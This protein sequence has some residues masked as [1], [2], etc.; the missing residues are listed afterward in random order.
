MEAASSTERIAEARRSTARTLRNA[1]SAGTLHVIMEI[2]VA[3]LLPQCTRYGRDPWPP[4]S[5]PSLSE[6]VKFRINANR[7]AMHRSCYSLMLGSRFS[8]FFHKFSPRSFEVTRTVPRYH[9]EDGRGQQYGIWASMFVIR[10]NL[11]DGFSQCSLLYRTMTILTVKLAPIPPSAGTAA[12]PV[13]M[14]PNF[15]PHFLFEDSKLFRAVS[16]LS[17]SSSPPSSKARAHMLATA[18]G[19]ATIMLSTEPLPT[20]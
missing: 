3:G 16:R 6:T 8:F 15:T 2:W 1:P 7:Y 20:R 19:Q 9:H 10:E 11:D 18:L 14:D 5:T 4:Q 13:K 17:S 12:T